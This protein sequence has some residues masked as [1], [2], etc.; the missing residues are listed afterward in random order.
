MT[1]SFAP[2]P[3]LRNQKVRGQD[4]VARLGGEEF[5]VMLPE[6]DISGARIVAENIRQVIEKGRIRRL[7]T[8]DQI[9][10]IT[11]SIGISRYTHGVNIIDLMDRADKALYVSK[12]T[13][14]NRVTVHDPAIIGN[15]MV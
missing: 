2:L 7:D 15:A 8:K 3:K 11:I 1:K 9:G 5:A 14:R 10:G 12:N 4:L 6:T 13:G